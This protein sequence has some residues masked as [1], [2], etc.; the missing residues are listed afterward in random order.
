MLGSLLRRTA[1]VLALAAVGLAASA[2]N[3]A[4]LT[5]QELVVD[6]TQNATTAQR[7]AALHACAHVTPETVPEPVT[8]DKLV[9]DQVSDVRFRTDHASDKDIA[10]LEACLDRQP[11]VAGFETPDLTG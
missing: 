7:L 3:T 11:D 6:F 1:P 8:R 9:S 4:A 5:K 2:C 10:E